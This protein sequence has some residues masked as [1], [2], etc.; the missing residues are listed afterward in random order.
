MTW[1]WQHASNYLCLYRQ[2]RDK[3]T[4]YSL[5]SAVS[6]ICY[7]Q[8][9]YVSHLDVYYNGS[10]LQY[11]TFSEKETNKTLP[12]NFTYNLCKKLTN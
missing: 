8:S 2:N 1:R 10:I 3:Q 6:K 7:P 12:Q 5:A 4:K 11:F 9:L